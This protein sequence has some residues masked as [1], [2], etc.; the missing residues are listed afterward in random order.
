[1]IELG[2]CLDQSEFP[3]SKTGGSRPPS[4]C[5][6]RFIAHKVAA[7]ERLIDRFGAY[8][9]TILFFNRGCLYQA[10]AEGVHR[11]VEGQ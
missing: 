9:V 1:M 11:Q 8:L 5:G 6:T 10:E 4:A 3:A 2:A 7:L